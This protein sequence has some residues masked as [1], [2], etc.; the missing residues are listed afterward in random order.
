M[1]GGDYSGCGWSRSLQK[2]QLGRS[3][4][5]TASTGWG[6]REPRGSAMHTQESRSRR[7]LLGRTQGCRRGGQRAPA[8]SGPRAHLAPQEPVA[9]V[10]EATFV[11]TAQRLQGLPAAPLGGHGRAV[12]ALPRRCD[13]KTSPRISRAITSSRFRF[14]G[15]ARS[16]TQQPRLRKTV[17]PTSGAGPSA[18]LRN[19]RARRCGNFSPAACSSLEPPCGSKWNT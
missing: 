8:A 15:G 16:G 18:R 4:P 11:G 6:E 19:Q 1:D 3:V 5:P 9:V 13:R 2:E 10:A 12:A 14:R 17:C 7:W